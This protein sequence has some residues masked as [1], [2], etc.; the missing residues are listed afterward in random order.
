MYHSD[1]RPKGESVRAEVD[2][3]IIHVITGR[4]MHHQ[5]RSDDGLNIDLG[6]VSRKFL[7]L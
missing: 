7:T 2:E 4:K 5:S 1:L 3:F 6:P